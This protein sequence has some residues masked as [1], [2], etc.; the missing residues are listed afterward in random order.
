MSVARA[1]LVARA[2]VL[3]VAASRDDLIARPP[4]E[5]EWNEHARLTKAGLCISALTSFEEFFQDRVREVVSKLHGYSPASRGMPEAMKTALVNGVFEAVAA[6]IKDKERFGLSD[7]R[8]FLVTQAAKIASFASAGLD[9][10][11]LALS[12]SNSN[13]SWKAIENAL[14]AFGIENPSSVLSGVARR[15]EGGIFVAKDHFE[16]VL[17]SRHLVAHTSDADIPLADVLQYVDRITLMAASFDI[18]L[19]TAASRVISAA[20]ANDSPVTR[21][22]DVKLR[23]VENHGGQWRD[24]PENRNRAHNRNVDRS[25]TI[26][27]SEQEARLR[28]E[29][30]V[31]RRTGPNSATHSWSTPLI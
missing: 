19:S 18:V 31:V 1:K 5:V 14:L 8:S 2:E 25:T 21:G 16:A 29:C 9:P 11:E 20:H 22:A 27:R 28:G 6:R 3:R 12:S 15:I 30:V 13:V 10:S 24:R 17:R 4:A 23:F 7:V 26:G